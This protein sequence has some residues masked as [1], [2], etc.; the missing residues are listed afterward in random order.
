MLPTQCLPLK[1]PVPGPISYKRKNLWNDIQICFCPLNHIISF[2]VFLYFSYIAQRTTDTHTHTLSA[3]S[4]YYCVFCGPPPTNWKF[5]QIKQ[6][7]PIKSS[8]LCSRV[9]VCVRTMDDTVACG[10]Q[11]TGPELA[12]TKYSIFSVCCCCVYVSVYVYMCSFPSI[13]SLL[14][15]HTIIN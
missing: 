2:S 1:N 12:N 14:S 10:P 5:M 4:F 6:F 15:T 8:A 11:G 7:L 3:G 13:Y 9:C